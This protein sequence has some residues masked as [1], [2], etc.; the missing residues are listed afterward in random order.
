MKKRLA[1]H[2]AVLASA[3]GVFAA[4]VIAKMVEGSPP[5]RPSPHSR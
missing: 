1:L 4:T 2:L 3:V 5:D